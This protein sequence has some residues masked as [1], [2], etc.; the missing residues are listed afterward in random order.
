M[1]SLHDDNADVMTT[2]LMILGKTRTPVCLQMTTKGELAAVLPPPAT[3]F[4]KS[5]DFWLTFRPMMRM[6]SM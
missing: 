1:F 2:A 6:A 3:A 5:G 4:N